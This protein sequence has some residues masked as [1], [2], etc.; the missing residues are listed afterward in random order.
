MRKV[1]F[2]LLGC[3]LLVKAQPNLSGTWRLK[4]SKTLKG[5]S[6]INAVPIL[7]TINQEPHVINIDN[8]TNLG[9]KDTL[10]SENINYGEKVLNRSIL[11][12]SGR[13]K[14]IT[15]EYTGNA[16]IRKSE[17]FTREDSTK[18]QISDKQ[19][20]HLST[21]GLVLYF[22]R[23]FDGHDDFF[24]SAEYEKLTP[25]QIA[26]ETAACR[27]LDFVK[28][29][30]WE[31]VKAKAK[32]ENKYIFVDCY[33]TWCGPCKV[34]DRF[35]YPLNIVGDAMN[36]QFI[37]VKLQ[38]DSTK[39]DPSHIK[40]LY[41]VARKFENEYNINALPAY[42]IFSPHGQAVHKFVGKH[43]AQQFIK[44]I[45]EAKIPGKQ[46]YTL[47]N[48]AKSGKIAE[49]EYFPIAKKLKEEFGENELAM[50][51]ARLYIDR[52]LNKQDEKELLRKEQL[53]F[54]VRHLKA[55]T[56]KDKLFKVIYAN[57]RLVDS[58]FERKPVKEWKNSLGYSFVNIVLNNSVVQPMLA[59]AQRNNKTPDWNVM[60]AE[61]AR[62]VDKERAK[63]VRMDAQ[64]S[65]LGIF[66]Q[67]RDDAEYIKVARQR[68]AQKDS[69]YIYPNDL[70]SYSRAV[71]TYSNDTTLLYQA[72]QWSNRATEFGKNHMDTWGADGWAAI[73]KEGKAMVLY[74]LG[75]KE[76]AIGLYKECIA[77]MENESFL[78]RMTQALT[79]IIKNEPLWENYGKTF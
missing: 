21:D 54:G 52:Y 75:K 33:A 63:S 62:F 34:M 20:F 27:G 74:R 24:V 77:N 30:T 4:E 55:I 14:Q 22:D 51:V 18:V 29:L 48:M 16:W 36:G 31:Q 11:P 73:W 7:M 38:M 26:K 45:A 57:E 37:A 40:Q 44:L 69:L 32:K 53:D 56:P 13:K 28:G 25:E 68:V 65:W 70:D 35:V 12:Q 2:I 41:P 17:I 19:M 72:L 59:T 76:E 23:D 6:F 79:S 42:L 10:I 15:F 3:P 46:L 64:L 9:D 50:E 61:L 66:G 5:E 78:L 1:F 39:N 49:S 58:L 8:T 71:F 60:D 47:F 43:D 67:Q